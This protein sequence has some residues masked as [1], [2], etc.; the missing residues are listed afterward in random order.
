MNTMIKSYM[1]K[2]VDEKFLTKVKDTIKI[3]KEKGGE[4]KL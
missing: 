3:I 4:I 1:S 2:K